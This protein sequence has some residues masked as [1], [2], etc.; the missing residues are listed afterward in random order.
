MAYAKRLAKEANAILVV[1]DAIEWPFEEAVTSGAVAELRKSIESS[2][3][4]KLARLLPRSSSDGS[5]AQ[6]VLTLGKASAAIIKVARARSVDLIV[7]GVSG[8][9]ATDVALLGSTT[10]QVIREGTRPVLTVRTG[11]P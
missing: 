9:G 3:R 2:A 5:G 10:H 7:I 4:D 11:T 8:R 6:A 1:M